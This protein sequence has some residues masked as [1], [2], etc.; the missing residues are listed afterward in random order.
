MHVCIYM[1]EQMCFIYCVCMHMSAC[2]CMYTCTSSIL[3]AGMQVHVCVCPKCM[4]ACVPSTCASP[5]ES[6]ILQALG[7]HPTIINHHHEADFRA[8]LHG[9]MEQWFSILF[10]L[11]DHFNN[12]SYSMLTVLCSLCQTLYVCSLIYSSSDPRRQV[13]LPSHFSEE[14][15]GTQGEEGSIT[16]QVSFAVLI[17]TQVCDSKACTLTH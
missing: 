14:Q 10:Q 12:K 16:Q 8:S 17:P 13:W 2:A 6:D 7:L 9:A 11:V 1:R 5:I 15:T 4:C 3:Y